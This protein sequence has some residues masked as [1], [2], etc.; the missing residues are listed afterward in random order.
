MRRVDVKGISIPPAYTPT[1]AGPVVLLGVAAE[2][3][4]ILPVPHM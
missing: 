4:A 2:L 3:L 1:F